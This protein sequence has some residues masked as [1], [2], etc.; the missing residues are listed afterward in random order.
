M[1]IEPI[2]ATPLVKLKSHTE[3]LELIEEYALSLPRTRNIYNTTSKDK[4]VLNNDELKNLNSHIIEQVN[5]FYESVAGIPENVKP[6]I[7]QSWCTFSEKGESMH[8]HSHPNSLY[9][10]VY[11][12]NANS[13]TDYITFKKPEQHE[14]VMW[15]K[16]VLNIYNAYEFRFPVAS[17][18]LIM[19]PSSIPHS[20]GSSESEG[21]RISI[22]F[23]TF[24]AGSLGGYNAL[25]NLNIGPFEIRRPDEKVNLP[26]GV[27]IVGNEDKKE[28][29]DDETIELKS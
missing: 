26:E 7:T 4:I 10:G 27:T 22:A 25:T 11:Y 8:E 2:F 6:F 5:E 15:Y 9:S 14:P 19:F 20:F 18:D 17:G 24:L 28:L 16:K 13:E 23:N 21:T 3:Y 29:K 1:I 12:V